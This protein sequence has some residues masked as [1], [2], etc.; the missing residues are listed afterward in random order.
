MLYLNTGFFLVIHA[1]G[2]CVLGCQMLLAMKLISLAFD[3]GY[4]DKNIPST[5][6]CCGYLF[7]VGTV[8]F[9]PWTSY[10]SYVSSTE[11]TTFVSSSKLTYSTHLFKKILIL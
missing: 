7:H 2:L 5:I 3:Y 8:I 1:I 9:G 4:L 6:S 11:S 10:A